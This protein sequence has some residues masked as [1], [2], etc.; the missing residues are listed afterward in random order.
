MRSYVYLYGALVR[1]EQLVEHV[2]CFSILH[3]SSIFWEFS[4]A[5]DTS[6]RLAVLYKL[7]S[8][9]KGLAMNYLL[10]VSLLFNEGKQQFTYAMRQFTIMFCT[11][12]LFMV[13]MYS[14]VQLST[15]A[16]V[17]LQI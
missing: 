17:S 7:G 12:S 16:K 8:P 6:H 9:A 15:P 4:V 13:I 11:Y 1:V 5:D 14:Y 3:C 2:R 10:P